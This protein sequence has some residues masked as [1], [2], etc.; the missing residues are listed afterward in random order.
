MSNLSFFTPYEEIRKNPESLFSIG[1]QMRD[2]EGIVVCWESKKEI[3]E[4]ITPPCFEVAGPYVN[5]YIITMPNN[6][7]G[8]GYN[9]TALQIP[10]IYNG[11][12]GIYFRSHFLD[13]AGA[14]GGT[15][16]GREMA[17]FPKKIC[18]KITLSRRNN[19]F[20]GYCEKDGVRF[21][22]IEATLG[23]Y[24]TP[25]AAEFFAP[26]EACQKNM[27]TMFFIK[28]DLEEDEN[29]RVGFDNARLISN[30]GDTIYSQWIPAN[31]KIMLQSTENAPWGEVE[32][33]RAI[34]GGYCKFSNLA[35]S[36]KVLTQLN[37]KELEPYMMTSHYDCGY[38]DG[39]TERKF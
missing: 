23:E 19:Y 28:W 2:E 13:G 21:L 33:V 26:N 37:A 22:D 4:K 11:V 3:L 29:G 20:H 38:I 34:G 16:V 12:P 24:N 18:E 27:G 10:V 8:L 15:F 14:L 36:C 7:F 39:Y 6:N 35:S 5:A 25:E 17:G 31:V 30:H 1:C 32:V 9:E